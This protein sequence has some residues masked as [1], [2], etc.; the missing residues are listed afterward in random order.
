[1][2]IRRMVQPLRADGELLAAST[3]T[4]CSAPS[5]LGAARFPQTLNVVK[6]KWAL[7]WRLASAKCRVWPTQ[8]VQFLRP[9]RNEHAGAPVP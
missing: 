9:S 1:M 4:I 8:E 7:G 5:G 3:Q 6:L 2:V